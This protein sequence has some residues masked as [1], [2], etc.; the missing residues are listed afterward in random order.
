MTGKETETMKCEI[1]KID[2]TWTVLGTREDGTRFDYRFESK[3]KA[4]AWVKQ[5]T[6]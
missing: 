4:Q 6:E 2:G 5:F 3:R 1:V